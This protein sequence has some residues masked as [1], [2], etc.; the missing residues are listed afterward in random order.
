MPG[1][2][3]KNAAYPS[4][5]AN[6]QKLERNS[7]MLYRIGYIEQMGTGIV[8]MKNAAKEAMVSEPEFELYSADSPRR[9]L[10]TGLP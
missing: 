5:R 6:S 3:L 9:R 8:R 10:L 1:R 7:I 2:R 4:Y